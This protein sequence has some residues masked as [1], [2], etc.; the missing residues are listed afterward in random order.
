MNKITILGNGQDE[1]FDETANFRGKELCPPVFLIGHFKK[2]NLRIGLECA[3][4]LCRNEDP[5][6]EITAFDTETALPKR[7]TITGEE[8]RWIL[9]PLASQEKAVFEFLSSGETGGILPDFIARTAKRLPIRSLTDL[10]NLLA[11][12]RPGPL[13]YLKDYEEDRPCRLGM[14]SEIARPTR[15]VLLYKERQEQA[16]ELL[17][18]CSPEEAIRLCAKNRGPKSDRP[19]REQLVSFISKYRGIPLA[20][21]EKLYSG[22]HYYTGAD[23]RHRQVAKTACRIFLKALEYLWDQGEIPR[24]QADSGK[25]DP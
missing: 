5:V 10:E 12:C 21:A 8:I 2:Q 1:L 23:I 22:W 17:T 3:I 6:Y 18:G 11:L 7:I 9:K 20:E 15:G 16:L 25:F 14:A 19:A 4:R 24:C 13:M